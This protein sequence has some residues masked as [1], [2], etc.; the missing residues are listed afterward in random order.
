MTGNAGKVLTVNSGAT[1]AEWDNIPSELPAIASGDAG[2]VLKVNAGETAVEWATDSTGSYTAGTGIDI[3]G[4]AISVDTTTVAMKSDIPAAEL[5]TISAGDA[6]KVLKVNSGE[7]G[8]EW[9]NGATVPSNTV[10]S[11]SIT[12]TQFSNHNLPRELGTRINNIAANGYSNYPTEIE[13]TNGTYKG[14]YSFDILRNASYPLYEVVFRGEK[15]KLVFGCNGSGS[16]I[17]ATYFEYV[18]PYNA[19]TNITI[20]N[21]TISASTGPSYSAGNGIDINAN[22]EITVVTDGTLS[23]S[24]FGLLGINTTWLAGFVDDIV[25]PKPFLNTLQVSYEDNG[26]DVYLINLTSQN[27]KGNLISNGRWYWDIP[28]FTISEAFDNQINYLQELDITDTEGGTRSST[29]TGTFYWDSE[30]W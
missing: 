15:K 9:G 29:G 1:A 11:Y 10:L 3:T 17:D 5:P 14:F 4:G 25:N 22:N 7:T 16:E 6:G 13:I 30:G 23:L 8:V 18:S 24:G 2:K 27:L 28:N 21:G 26:D 12:E 19:G 20:N